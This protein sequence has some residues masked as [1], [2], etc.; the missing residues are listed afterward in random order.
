MQENQDVAP[1]PVPTAQ[2]QFADLGLAEP[3]L[4]A[5][6]EKGYTHPTPIQAKAIPTVLK[7]LDVMGGAQTGTGKTAAFTLPILHR[8]LPK[9]N[10]S[11]SP[12]RHP[13]RAL[14]LSPTR[15]LAIQIEENVEL[16]S[17]HTGLRS[18][19]VFGGMD[20]KEQTAIVRAGVEVLI[21]T[22]GRLLDH[23]EQKNLSLNQ[24]EVL[25]LDEADRMLDMGF[26]PDVM[27]ILSLLPK[28]RQSLLFSATFNNEIK[29]LA[30]E[31]LRAPVLIEV[32]RRN[33]AAETV[34]Q[35]CYFVREDAKRALLGHIMRTN[36]MTQVLVFCRRKMDTGRLASALKRD[37]FNTAA[38]HGDKSQEAR[39]EALDDFK[40]GKINVLVATDVA[41]RGIDIAELPA[42]VNF[43]LPYVAEDYV[44]RI[45]RTGRAGASGI[46]IS[47]VSPEDERLL[48][49]IE[50]LL[51]KPVR[52]EPMP[53]LSG[54]RR[55]PSEGM[56]RVVPPPTQ[57]R[58]YSSTRRV[59][60]ESAYD[61]NPDQPMPNRAIGLAPRKKEVAALLMPKKVPTA[62]V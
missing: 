1:T 61:L 15:E 55:D 32:A 33:T 12:A 26:I 50:K 28:E 30:D 39:I 51:K 47:L 60:D 43:E 57:P 8:L 35:S 6:T 58:D 18:T 23:I 41:A 44:H 62:Q 54:R 38:I 59:K 24:V 22:P 31:M 29:K 2:V 48:L 17:K 49:D 36:N 5:V 34:E 52:R 7:G 9:A 10:S 53:D 56:G 4:R 14:I 45:G 40:S 3:I 20:M 46:A 19:V 16:Y 21:A 42:V 27:R 25:V 37:G 11:P 13:V